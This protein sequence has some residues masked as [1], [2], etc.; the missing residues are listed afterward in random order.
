MISRGKPKIAADARSSLTLLIV[1]VIAFAVA[2][3]C[4]RLVDPPLVTRPLD[5]LAQQVRRTRR[6]SSARSGV[7][8]GD[9]GLAAMSTPC[10]R[11]SKIS[12]PRPNALGSRVEQSA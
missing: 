10:D 3:P 2:A 7:A 5:D 12:A 11:A 4:S 1:L 6:D 9:R 8:R